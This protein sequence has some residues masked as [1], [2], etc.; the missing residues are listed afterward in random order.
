MYAPL[1]QELPP[2]LGLAQIYPIW[3]EE[4]DEERVAVSASLVDPFIAILRDDASLLLLQVDESGDLDE[5]PLPDD[6]STLKCR[7]ICLYHD[8]T[9]TFT[10]AQNGEDGSN[11]L[12]FILTSD[13]KISVS[14]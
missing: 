8:K 3:D 1:T 13:Y 5:V 14:D 2:E 7:S 6:I 10:P 11:M 12:L 9:H 4:T